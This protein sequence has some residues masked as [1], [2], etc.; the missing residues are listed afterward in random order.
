M[1]LVLVFLSLKSPNL[2]EISLLMK[3]DKE[4]RFLCLFAL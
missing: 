1:S 3:I 4:R 2:M